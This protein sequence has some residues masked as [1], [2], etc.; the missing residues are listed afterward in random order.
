MDTVEATG[1]S[2]ISSLFKS[3]PM[4]NSKFAYLEFPS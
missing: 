1:T 3:N 2:H 4:S